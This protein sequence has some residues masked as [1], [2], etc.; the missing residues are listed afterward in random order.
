MKKGLMLLVLAVVMGFAGVANAYFGK[1]GT[2]NYLGTDYNL[3]YEGEL[4]G[5]GLVW[6]DYTRGA[7][8]WSEQVSWATGLGESLTVTLDPDYMSTIN[9]STGWRLPTT[10]NGIFAWGSDGTTTA[11]YNITTS[12]MGHLYYE[13]LGNLGSND[14][15]GNSQPGFGLVNKGPFISLQGVGYW[16]GTSSADPD[17]VDDIA[18]YFNFYNGAQNDAV[19]NLVREYALAVHPGVVSAV[20]IP[21]ALWLLGSGIVGLAGFRRRFKK[22]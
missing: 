21:S 20:P 22:S 1:I 3:I 9:W 19:K 17:Y 15:D 10:M 14:T 16:S 7:A 13:S 5:Q 6:L 11:G 18:W 4:G 12:E 2:A 8:F